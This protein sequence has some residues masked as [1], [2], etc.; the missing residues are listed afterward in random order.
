M[1]EEL[2]SYINERVDEQISWYEQKS[3]FNKFRFRIYQLVVIVASA[4]IPII[5]LGVPL[6]IG[7]EA[8]FK[9]LGVTAILGGVITI[10]TALSQMD[11]YFQ[12]WVLYRTTVEALKRE[13]FLYINN[14]ADYSA[15]SLDAK[16]KLLVERVEAM[17]ASEN[18]K[19][20]SL[21]QQAKQQLDQ[22]LNEL[23]EKQR[24]INKQQKQEILELQ[25]FRK[26][27]ELVGNDYG[28]LV[29]SSLVGLKFPA[30]KEAI[31]AF[32][33]QNKTRIKDADSIATRIGRLPSKEYASTQDITNELSKNAN[34]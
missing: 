32:I 22:Q 19:F 25:E 27:Y 16:N 20:L 1:S 29:S 9:A 2:P 14:A 13:K 34:S 17:L 3:A 28:K 8:A 5:N 30:N 11:S 10:I 21:Q 24:E 6:G 4:T 12:T 15:L 18:S 31:L 23:L 26:K 7:P 33:E